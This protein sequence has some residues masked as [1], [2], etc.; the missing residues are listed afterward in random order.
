MI[1]VLIFFKLINSF[2]I[3]MGKKLK[4]LLKNW[5]VI[6]EMGEYYVQLLDVLYEFVICGL[7]NCIM[8]FVCFGCGV[9]F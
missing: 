2:I 8:L 1:Y 5:R 6:I 3:L 7:I 4:L 9:Y